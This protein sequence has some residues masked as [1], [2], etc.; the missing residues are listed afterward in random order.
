V[1][2][3]GLGRSFESLIPSNLLDESFDPSVADDH[4]VSDLRHIKLSEI[5]P[6]PDQPRRQFDEAALEELTA[7]IAAH[8]V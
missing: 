3:K 8:G 4:K 6:D 1:S 2:K 7:S 5:K